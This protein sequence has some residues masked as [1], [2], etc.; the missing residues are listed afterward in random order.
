MEDKKQKKRAG[1]VKDDYDD[2]TLAG[3]MKAAN[4]QAARR[5]TFGET[6]DAPPELPRMRRAQKLED[7][8]REEESDTRLKMKSTRGDGASASAGRSGGRVS[9]MEQLR[10]NA[11]EAYKNLKRSNRHRANGN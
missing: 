10:L 1:P 7:A 4:D 9:E 11:V 2:S 5:Q 8:R 3:M 6:N